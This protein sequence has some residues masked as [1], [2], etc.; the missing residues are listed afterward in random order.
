MNLLTIF[1]FISPLSVAI[2]VLAV[3]CGMGAALI[4]DLLFSFYSKDKSF[5]RME[6]NTLEILAKI[7]KIALYVIIVSG[8]LVFLS[9]VEKYITSA[10]FLA[11]ITILVVLVLNGYILN[12]YV[13]S[14]ILARGSKSFFAPNEKVVRQV[15]FVGGAIS[16]VSWIALF[17]LGNSE[18]IPY[19]Y[20]TILGLY[21]S[22]VFLGAGVA[23][24]VEALE[25]EF[26]KRK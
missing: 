9:D 2:H 16:V 1:E 11:K 18:A 14:H 6:I 25:F 17:M 7:V 21:A 24:M 15:A 19:S 4:A 23:L 26:K 13:W 12:T 3:V 10:K 8:I 20:T 5:S 22:I